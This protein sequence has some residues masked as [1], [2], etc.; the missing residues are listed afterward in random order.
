[1]KPRTIALALGA[2]L[3]VAAG[4]WRLAPARP[5][6][7]PSAP[8]AAPAA[9][10]ALAVT[11][12]DLAWT[13]RVELAREVPVSGTLRAVQSAWVKAR[14]A[15]ELRELVLR[16]GDA[17]R[18]GQVLARVEPTE[19][20]ARLRQ[21]EQQAQAAQA[22]IEIA[23]RQWDNNR[24]LVQQGFISATALEQSSNNLAI[25]Q[26]NHRAALAAVDVARKALDDTVLRAPLAGQIAQRPAQ[27]GERVGVDTRIVEIV[28]LS[29][30]ELE[31]LVPPAEA[32]ELRPGQTARLRVEGLAEPVPAR[33]VR[34]APAA[35]AASRA[36]PVYLRLE[37]ASAT[38]QQGL[39]QGLFAQGTVRTGG[40]PTLAVPLAALRTDR[41]EPYLQTVEGGAVAHRPVR[42]GERG[43]VDGE[44]WVA[45]EGV[46]AGQTVL[47][48]HVGP[49]RAGQPVRL[50]AGGTADAAAAA[51]A[52]TSR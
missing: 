2:A 35:Q 39:R 26:A 15:G 19:Y 40:Q 43:R 36:V 10:N 30:V 48:G 7:G 32:A 4:L 34:I 13:E 37:P 20:E 22:Q 23:Q 3:L 16:E 14:V 29:A 9:D 49:L 24:A 47:R 50:P 45:V 11:A 51:T 8:V 6:T 42:T 33:V 27:P 28:D 18:A 46:E 1:M 52:G 12:A 17:V 44:I 25:A 31:A 41:A 21:A 38:Q 5:G